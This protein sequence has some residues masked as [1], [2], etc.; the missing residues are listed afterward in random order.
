MTDYE[1]ACYEWEHNQSKANEMRPAPNRDDYDEHG[2]LKSNPHV[3]YEDNKILDQ[4]LIDT[5][6]IEYAQQNPLKT[7]INKSSCIDDYALNQYKTNGID[8]QK[9]L[10]DLLDA[11]DYSFLKIDGTYDRELTYPVIDKVN[12]IKKL[13]SNN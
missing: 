3:M 6:G 9:C 13:L 12:F 1:R 7:D 11:I 5:Y 8:Y 2:Y 4:Y 10:K